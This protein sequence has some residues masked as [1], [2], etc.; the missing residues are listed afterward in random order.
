MIE[1]GQI[2]RSCDPRGGPNIRI[3]AWTDGD[4]HAQVVDSTTGSNP[5]KILAST[6]H[7]SFDTKRRQPRR[8]GYALAVATA[9][10][11]LYGGAGQLLYIGVAINPERRWRRHKAERD[12]WPMVTEK[13]VEWFESRQEAEA[14]ETA[15][16][17]AELP[18]HN[19]SHHPEREAEQDDRQAL[20]RLA[21]LTRRVK[22]AAAGHPLG[23]LAID[24]RAE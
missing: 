7:S 21:W 2:Y 14:A 16:I 10:Y 6:L 11:R 4:T 22:F 8:R 3:V 12:W 1:V 13:R 5:R 19:V 23:A 15:A 9:L 17:R 24:H 18:E 20:V